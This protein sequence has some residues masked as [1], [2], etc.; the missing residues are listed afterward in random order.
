MFF[1]LKKKLVLKHVINQMSSFI[2]FESDFFWKKKNC[3]VFRKYNEKIG[4]SSMEICLG[5]LQILC[6]RGVYL[7]LIV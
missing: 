7:Q 5:I 3:F 1:L 2:Y 4:F 6:L